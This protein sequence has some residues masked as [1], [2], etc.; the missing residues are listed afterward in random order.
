MSTFSSKCSRFS[1]SIAFSSL[2]LRQIDC[3]KSLL[4]HKFISTKLS[5]SKNEKYRSFDYCVNLVKKGDYENYLATLL[6]AKEAQRA[7]FAL[8][9]FNVEL[10]QV[11]DMVSEKQIGLMRMRF[12][13]DSIDKIFKGEPPQTPVALEMSGAAGYFKLSKRWAERMVDARTAQMDSD[14]FLSI[15]DV[16]EY[17]EQS[18]SSLYYLLL[19]CLGIRNVQADHAA[20]HLGKAQGL[21]TLLR[22]IPFHAAKRSVLIPM[23]IFGKHKVPQEDF[24]RGIHSQAMADALFEVAS[25]ANQHLEKARALQS[26]LPDKSYTVFLNAAVCDHYLKSLQYANFNPFDSKL[27]SRNNLLGLTMYWNRFKKKF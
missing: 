12:W 4:A 7:A 13:K 2:F 8:R 25:L 22:S 18:N 5:K 26:S 3:T 11:R 6:L 21:V 15:K 24:I 14:F 23:E 27:Q 9:A 16:E 20:S 1:K 17:A 10:A 19:E